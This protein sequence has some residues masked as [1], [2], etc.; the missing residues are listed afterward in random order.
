MIRPKKIISH[1]KAE[2]ESGI[3]RG[4][5]SCRGETR[6]R[7]LRALFEGGRK[8]Y[9]G[10]S[11]IRNRAPLGPYTRTMPRVLWWSWGGGL[12]LM[13]EVLL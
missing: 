1:E 7:C 11:L 13:S 4:E 12:F 2:T 6:H 9:R 8:A 5:I 10:T 3:F